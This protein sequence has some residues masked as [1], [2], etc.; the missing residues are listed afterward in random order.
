MSL[1]SRESSGRLTPFQR[2]GSAALRGGPAY[3]IRQMV[4]AVSSAIKQGAILRKR[5]GGRPAPHFRA[6]AAGDPEARHEILV[7][8]L[9]GGHP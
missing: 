4:P 6:L 1:L 3:A 5:N 9:P 8:A 2:A 7:R